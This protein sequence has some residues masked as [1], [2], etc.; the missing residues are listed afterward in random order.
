MMTTKG[1]TFNI[2]KADQKKLYDF[3]MS[4]GNFSGYVKDLIRRDIA[5]RERQKQKAAA[6]KVNPPK[7]NG[8][9]RFSL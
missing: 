6:T 7:N 9:V 4:T 2:S 5:T 3:A 1:V 8:G